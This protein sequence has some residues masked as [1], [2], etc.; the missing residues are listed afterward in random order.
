MKMSLFSEYL[1]KLACDQAGAF[2]LIT[3]IYRFWNLYNLVPL[4]IAVVDNLSKIYEAVDTTIGAAI[5]VT[6]CCL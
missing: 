1:R 4:A 3:R 2:R 5:A 6:D